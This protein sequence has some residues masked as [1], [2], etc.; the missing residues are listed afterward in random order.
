MFEWC[1]ESSRVTDKL[2]KKRADSSETIISSVAKLLL[3]IYVCACL[4]TVKNSL[5][6]RK[7]E[8]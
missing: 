3:G 2:A 1:V 4:S 6:N 8:A 5:D 7:R